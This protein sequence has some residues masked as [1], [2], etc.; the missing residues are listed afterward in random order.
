MNFA[1]FLSERRAEQVIQLP[2]DTFHFDQPVSLGNSFSGC[3]FKGNRTVFDGGTP[4][5]SWNIT[6]DGLWCA[7]LPCGHRFLYRNGRMVVNSRYPAEKT[8]CCRRWE[9]EQKPGTFEWVK[10]SL[11]HSL[12]AEIRRDA[13]NAEIVLYFGWQCCRL[14]GM[15]ID[16][17]G[18]DLPFDSAM[19]H[20]PECEFFFEDMP[21]SYLSCGQWHPDPDERILY[22]KPLPGENPGDAVFFS[23]G[24]EKLLL[25]EGIENAVFENIVFRHTGDAAIRNSHQ[26]DHRGSAA[27]E[28]RNA[29]NCVFRN[30]RFE[31]LSC[32]GADLRHGATGNLFSRCEFVNLG[33][34]AVKMSGGHAD[35]PPESYCGRN[36]VENCSISHGGQRWSGSVALLIRHSGENTLRGNDISDFPYSGISCGW[37]WGYQPSIA[38]DNRILGNSIHD[39]GHNRLVLDMGGIYLLGHQPGTI[40]AGNHI[41]NVSGRF[42]CWGIYLDEGASD[43][44][45]AENLVHNCVNEPF[46][47]HFG[48]HNKVYGNVLIAERGSAC[49][50]IT[51]GT[52]D[53]KANSFIPGDKVFDFSHNLCIADGMPF[54]MKYLLETPGKQ[55]MLDTWAGDY[56]FCW[57]LDPSC[58]VKFCDDYH[59]ILK[60]Y[61]PVPDSAFITSKRESHTVF[62]EGGLPDPSVLETCGMPEAVCRLYRQYLSR[63]KIRGTSPVPRTAGKRETADAVNSGEISESRCDKEL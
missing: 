20:A 40:V 43:I 29:K 10:N 62:G 3:V 55:E 8:I 60:T 36:T 58:G 53:R 2:A 25:L 41:Y 9:S 39:L 23:G 26:A 12:P 42:F 63:D 1:D 44:T 54:F 19:Y 61:T 30:C 59:Y 15:R 6:H 38:H 45:V 37:T 46:R 24:A 13:A 18:I 49:C 51:R 22:Y 31:S 21:Q 16:E 57:Q 50:A 33:S 11:R 5:R 32:W 14:R 52:M 56:N 34:G 28:L 47:V 17:E 35:D 48:K 7:P 27:L 4:V